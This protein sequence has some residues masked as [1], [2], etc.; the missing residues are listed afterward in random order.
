[1]KLADG[2]FCDTHNTKWVPGLLLGPRWLMSRG[3]FSRRRWAEVGRIGFAGLSGLKE[4]FGFYQAYR[5][6]T[7]RGKQ[8]ALLRFLYS[9]LCVFVPVGG[10][11]AWGGVPWVCRGLLA[12]S[13]SQLWLTPQSALQRGAG[14]VP[15]SWPPQEGGWQSTSVPPTPGRPWPQGWD[16]LVLASPAGVSS[17]CGPEPGSW[18]AAGECHSPSLR[19]QGLGPGLRA[20]V[21]TALPADSPQPS[22]VPRARDHQ[23]REALARHL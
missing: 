18:N 1:M 12:F 10:S 6:P 2:W 16:P 20:Q 11:R 19:F 5:E 9:P 13:V 4:K 22:P 3:V 21:T 17:E 14:R 7:A 8:L 23:G 15:R